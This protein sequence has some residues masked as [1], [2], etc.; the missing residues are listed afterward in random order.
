[1]VTTRARSD[2]PQASEVGSKRIDR[3]DLA[4][5]PVGSGTYT[6]LSGPL[7]GL[8]RSSIGSP[9]IEYWDQDDR[10]QTAC[11][12]DMSGL[13]VQISLRLAMMNPEIVA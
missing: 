11:I 2:R 3:P 1:M 9:P 8:H 12:V 7:R 5:R 13:R 10:A 4:S 6:D